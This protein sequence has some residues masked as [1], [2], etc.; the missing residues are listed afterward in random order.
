MM[1][2]IISHLNFVSVAQMTHL[3]INLSLEAIKL[4]GH[5]YLE[6]KVK[7]ISF[8]CSVE[9]NCSIFSEYLYFDIS[10]TL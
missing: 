5:C 8:E 1:M 10:L 4:G 2:M 7:K 9:I 6:E 3:E